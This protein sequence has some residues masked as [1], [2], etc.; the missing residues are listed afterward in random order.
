VAA[1]WFDGESSPHQLGCAVS[2]ERGGRR[3]GSGRGEKVGSGREL[4]LVGERISRLYGGVIEEGDLGEAA[5]WKAQA[6]RRVSRRQEQK[7]AAKAPALREE[8]SLSALAPRRQQRQDVTDRPPQT[9]VKHAHEALS[10]GGIVEPIVL[11]RDVERQPLLDQYEMCPVLV[12]GNGAVG[13]EAKLAAE[14]DGET[15][16]IIDGCRALRLLRRDQRRDAP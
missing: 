2:G 9:L 13:G 4:A 10:L 16:G 5:K 6:N 12:G 3:G 7:I 1:A 15:L 11:R 8:A 14:L